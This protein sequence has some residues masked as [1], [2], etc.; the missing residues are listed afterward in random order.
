MRDYDIGKDQQ[1]ARED[2]M[3]CLGI[4]RAYDD[5][6][7]DAKEFRAKINR[8]KRLC[9]PGRGIGGLTVVNAFP[10]HCVLRNKKGHARS[11]TYIVLAKYINFKQ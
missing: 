9:T 11:F 3:D 6:L 5:K 7:V 8:I 2:K 1:L 4:D 10:Y